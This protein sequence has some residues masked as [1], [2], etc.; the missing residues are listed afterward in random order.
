[1]HKLNAQLAKLDLKDSE[2]KI[3]ISLLSTGKASISDISRKTSI[4]RTT[5]YSPL[6]SLLKKGLLFKTTNKKRILYSAENPKKIIS[7]L[8][9]EKRQLDQKQKNIEKIIPELEGIFKNSFN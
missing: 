5:V 1:M 2:I 7:I 4:N 3:Y 6:E 9:A 8:K